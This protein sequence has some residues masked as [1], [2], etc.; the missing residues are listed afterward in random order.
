MLAAFCWVRQRE[1]TDYL[2]DLFIRVLQDIRLRARSRVEKEIVADY[3]KVGGKQQ[4]LFRLAQAMLTNPVGIIEEILYPIIGK[5]RLE[6]LVEEAKHQGPYQYSVQTHISGSYTHH[7]RQMLP[8]LL[9]VL[10]FRSNNEQYK[11]LIEAVEI[12]AAYLEEKDAYYP[13]EQ[14]VPIEDV[15]QKQWQS[16]IYQKDSNGR[17]RIRR[18]RYELCVLQSLR[19]KLRCK[20]IWVEAANRYRNPDEDVPVDFSDKRDEYYDALNLSQ[21]REAFVESLK[22]L[23]TDNLQKLNDSIPTNKAVEILPRGDGWIRLT[24]LAK[25]D[26]PTNLRYLKNQVKQRWWMTSLLDI[27][28]E[29]DFRISFTDNFKSLTGQ[30]RLPQEELQKRLLLCLLAWAVILG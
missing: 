13:L 27:L 11:P 22:Q 9:E 3:I 2:V 10:I 5:E 15:I 20:E 21:D 17:I 4:L 29:A 6:A 7:Y 30:Q 8:P 14:E 26:E 25:Q 24:P 1:I 12:V 18:V 23:M 19:N 16:W 28:K